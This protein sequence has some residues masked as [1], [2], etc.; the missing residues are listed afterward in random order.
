MSPDTYAL[1]ANSYKFIASSRSLLQGQGCTDKCFI[2]WHSALHSR[3]HRYVVSDVSEEPLPAF[4]GNKFVL[5]MEEEI[6]YE[7][8][9]KVSQANLLTQSMDQSP[10]SEANTSPG[11]QEIFRILWNLKFHHRFH[12]SQPLPYPEPDESSPCYSIIFKI[13]FNI[14]LP[15]RLMFPSNLFSSC[16]PTINVY[17]FINFW[18]QLKAHEFYFINY[19]PL[20]VSGT[21]VPIFRRINYIF[22]TTG[23]MSCLLSAAQLVG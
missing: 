15:H 2:L 7:R 10:S 12:N 11:S 14:I 19:A 16:F 21:H 18:F 1:P 23:S 6:W 8:D 3:T 22:T 17:A 5:K 20:H 9:Y 4:S 13:L